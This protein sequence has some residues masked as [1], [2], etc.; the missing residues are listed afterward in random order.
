VG[1]RRRAASAEILFGADLM[2]E[3]SAVLPPE[4]ARELQ[5][6]VMGC[7]RAL[8]GEALMLAD[9]VEDDLVLIKLAR[10]GSRLVLCERPG[11]R[12]KGKPHRFTGYLTDEVVPGRP[13]RLDPDRALFVLS[14]RGFY[15]PPDWHLTALADPRCW[16]ND[17]MQT[18]WAALAPA[19]AET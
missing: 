4:C 11:D 8:G 13:F 6:A 2:T 10:I 15:R 3:T 7:M 14:E 1:K 17:L 18:L 9:D 16:Y 12:A 19:L 5:I